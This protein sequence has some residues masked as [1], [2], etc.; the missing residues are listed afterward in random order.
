MGAGQSNRRARPERWRRARL[1]CL[2]SDARAGP[3]QGT[4]TTSENRQLGPV[5]GFCTRGTE[6][7]RR[8][9]MASGNRFRGRP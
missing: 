6:R 1:P 4:D 7:D 2:V 3:P 5:G 9:P 8:R